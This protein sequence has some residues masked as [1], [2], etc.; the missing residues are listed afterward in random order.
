MTIRLQVRK[1]PNL[2]ARI[3]GWADDARLRREVLAKVGFA[4]ERRAKRLAPVD[5]G[6][7]RASLSTAWAGHPG[8][9]ESEAEPGDEVSTPRRNLTVHVGSNVEYATPVHERHRTKGKFLKRAVEAVRPMVKR[10]GKDFKA[11]R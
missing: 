8:Q 6:R 7:L 10:L 1:R 3:G 2:H 11:G 4:V 9:I 5:H